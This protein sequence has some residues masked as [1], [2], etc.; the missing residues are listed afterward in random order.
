MALSAQ[1][2]LNVTDLPQ[3]AMAA[4]NAVH[5]E[6]LAIV[7]ALYAAL[8]GTLQTGTLTQEIDQL[9]EQW[10]VHTKAHF[11][12]ENQMMDTYDF[13]ARHV[14]QAEH[15]EALQTLEDVIQ[16]WRTEHDCQALAAYVKEIWPVWYVEHIATLDVVTSAFIKQAIAKTVS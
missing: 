6:E 13:P 4:M 5:Q 10:L 12:R 9:C 1:K 8:A 16:Q 7:N 11:D 15:A 3:V 2:I 14:H